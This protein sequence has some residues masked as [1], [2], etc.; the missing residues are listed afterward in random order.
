[1]IKSKTILARYNAVL[2]AIND[3]ENKLRFGRGSFSIA[4]VAQQFFCEKELELDYKYPQEPTEDMSSGKEG[5]ENITSLA[6]LVSKERAIEDAVVVRKK[7]ICIYEFGLGWQYKDVPIL[8]RVDEVW[9][10]NGGV[11]SISERKFTNSLHPYRDHQVQARQY[12]LGLDKMGFEVSSTMYNIMTFMRS[13]YDCVKLIDRSCAIFMHDK[14]TYKCKN[15]EAKVFSF[16][17]DRDKAIE[18]LDWA[19]CFWLKERK[20]TPSD[21]PAKCSACR[22]RDACDYV[23]S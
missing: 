16:P 5:H 4:D 12:C 15:G 9:F 7:P 13:C 6:T 1:M 11:V 17:F 22:R 8:G 14:N 19:L 10:Q 21:N 23:S 2:D 18:E 20:A 3:S